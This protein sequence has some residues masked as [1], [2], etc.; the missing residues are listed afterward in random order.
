MRLFVAVVA[1]EKL[2]GFADVGGDG[3]EADGGF[4]GHCDGVLLEPTET[5]GYGLADPGDADFHIA[6]QKTCLHFPSAF[7][8]NHSGYSFLY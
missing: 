7:G 5:E 3:G 8:T 4:V 6:L 2:A 1:E